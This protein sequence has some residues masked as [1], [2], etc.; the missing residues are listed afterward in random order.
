MNKKF[1]FSNFLIK[2]EFLLLYLIFIV[3][4]IRFSFYLFDGVMEGGDTRIYKIVAQNLY[5][6]FCLSLSNPEIGECLPHWGGNQPPGYSSF[7]ALVYKFG[8]SEKS[9]V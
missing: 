8:F 4:F 7:L 9:V 2:K 1:N 6:N 5:L 3:I